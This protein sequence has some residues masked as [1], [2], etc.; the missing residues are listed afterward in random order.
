MS[1]AGAS[2]SAPSEKR[3]RPSSNYHPLSLSLPPYSM[4]REIKK[5]GAGRKQYVQQAE[6]ARERRKRPKTRHDDAVP[7]TSD[8]ARGSRHV[9][10]L[11]GMQKV[12]EEAEETRR[13]DIMGT[14]AFFQVVVVFADGR[15]GLSAAARRLLASGHASSSNSSPDLLSGADAEDGGMEAD[16]IDDDTDNTNDGAADVL[17]TAIRDAFEP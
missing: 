3:P 15:V 1:G 4:P 14:S 2:T 10:G 12:R 7:G 9:L 6:S 16:W 11:A 8:N 13:L 5:I 17:T